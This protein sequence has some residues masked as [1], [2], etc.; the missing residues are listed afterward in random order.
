M[1]LQCAECGATKAIERHHVSYNPPKIILLCRKHHQETHNITPIEG[2]LTEIMRRH[3]LYTN[4][5]VKL[6]NRWKAWEKQFGKASDETIESFLVDIKKKQKSLL[7]EAEYALG[8]R[9][10]LKELWN[11][12]GVRHLAYLFAFADPARFPSLRKFL[13]YCGRKELAKVNKNYSRVASTTAHQVAI[14]LVRARNEE[15]YPLYK[16]IKESFNDEKAGVQHG[17]ALNRISTLWLKEFYK[18]FYEL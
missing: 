1:D 17:K 9:L 6:K 5:G 14:S 10:D 12:V 8:E 15:Y 4:L 3:R 2:E 16:E 18:K 13:Y 11:G 7:K